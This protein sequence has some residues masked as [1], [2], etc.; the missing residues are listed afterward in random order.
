M[1]KI[2]MA[3]RKKI[4]DRKKELLKPQALE[5]LNELERLIEPKPNFVGPGPW[6][7]IL[8]KETKLFPDSSGGK[9]VSGKEE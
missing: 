5:S 7:R 9:P 2:N 6:I 3:D 4:L 1:D 8:N